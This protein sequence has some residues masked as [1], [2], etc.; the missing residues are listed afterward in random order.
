MKVVVTSMSNIEGKI[1]IRMQSASLV[2]SLILLWSSA[3]GVSIIIAPA[4]LGLRNGQARLPRMAKLVSV[5]PF[6]L[7][8]SGD[9]RS[10]HCVEYPLGSV[11]TNVGGGPRSAK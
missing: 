11:S 7:G 4:F 6:I 8:L 3:A 2:S 1:G 9:R 5:M 10:S